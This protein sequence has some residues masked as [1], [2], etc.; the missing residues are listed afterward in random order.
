MYK[1]YCVQCLKEHRHICIWNIGFIDRLL[2]NINVKYCPEYVKI[3]EKG[4]NK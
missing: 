1:H 4:K 2:G 3:T